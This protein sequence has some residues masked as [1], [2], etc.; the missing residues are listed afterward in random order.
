M[1]R[2]QV[3]ERSSDPLQ[4]HCVLDE[5]VLLRSVGGP[6]VMRGQLRRLLE[7]DSPNV[8]V[9]VLP[10]AFGQHPALGGP[11]VVLEFEDSADRDIVYVES[12]AGGAY[13]EHASDVDFHKHLFE[14]CRAAALSPSASASL[15]T[16][17]LQASD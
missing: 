4:L 12:Y 1:V 16:A 11:F 6:E 17:R 15:I 9:Q 3:L 14:R 7:L 2:Q 10:L 13:L 5:A 8:T